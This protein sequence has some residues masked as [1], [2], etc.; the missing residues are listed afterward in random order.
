MISPQEA[1]KEI[2]RGTVE[3]IHENGVLSRLIEGKPLRIKLGFDPTAPDIHLGHTVILNKLRQFQILG[4]E[5][6]FLI[7]DFT[8]MIGD[9]TGNN[10]TRKTLTR[11]V[12]MENTK[13]YETQV[14]RIL[15]PNKTQ[16]T[17]NSLWISKLKT[18]DIIRLTATHT[19]ARM[20]E[21]DDFNKRYIR[22][23]PISIHEFLYPLLQGYDSVALQADIE[24]GGKDQRFNLLIGRELQKHFGQKPQCIVMTPLLEGLDGTQK[25]SKSLNNYIGITDPPDEMF[26]KIMSISDELMWRYYDLLSFRSELEV[27]QWRGKISKGKN[28]R[29][30]KILLAKELVMRFHNIKAAEKAHQNF[31]ERFKYHILPSNLDEVKLAAENTYLTIAYVLQRVGLV[32]TTSEAL[33]LITQG[34]VRIDGERVENTKLVISR[35]NS[36]L[37]QVGKRRFV[38]VKIT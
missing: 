6:I 15:D 26:G 5:I 33:R 36:H 19:V 11:D 3:I 20:L 38:K 9:P 10:V 12:I 13:T 23:Q 17:F 16:V 32:K 2:K 7:G 14:F 25:M 22:K 8:A 34:A 21:R 29:D 24:L 30:I 31:I 27:N 28:L 4:H 1:L 37:F 18:D 35:G